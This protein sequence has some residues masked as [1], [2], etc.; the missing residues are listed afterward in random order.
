MLPP[1]K[2]RRAC[3]YPASHFLAFF[4]LLFVKKWIWGCPLG[5]VTTRCVNTGVLSVRECLDFGYF[6]ETNNQ[7]ESLNKMK[8]LV[9]LAL[10]YIMSITTKCGNRKIPVNT[11]HTRKS[12]RFIPFKSVNFDTSRIGG[13]A[14]GAILP[15]GHSIVSW[16]EK[17]R[18]KNTFSPFLD[19][20]VNSTQRW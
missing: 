10:N 3:V 5:F 11:S 14:P 7:P 9:I 2:L 1:C 15:T 17:R 19:M 4:P 13:I 12:L 6:S 20:F 8:T 18:G 16:Q